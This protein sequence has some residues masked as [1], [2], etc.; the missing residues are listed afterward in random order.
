[1]DGWKVCAVNRLILLRKIN[2]THVSSAKSVLL[3]MLRPASE[4]GCLLLNLPFYKFKFTLIG[5]R[6]TGIIKFELHHNSSTFGM[7][8]FHNI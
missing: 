5:F 1:M 6:S 8:L 4:Q 3:L 2:S 7:T